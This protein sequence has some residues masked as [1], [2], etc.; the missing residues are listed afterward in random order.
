MKLMQL[1]PW[2]V[3]QVTGVDRDRLRWSAPST[4]ERIFI[5][6]SRDCPGIRSQ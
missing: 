1:S 6:G 2:R 5:G 4:L 3:N